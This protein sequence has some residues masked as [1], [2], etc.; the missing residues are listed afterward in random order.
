M[1]LGKLQTVK[2]TKQNTGKSVSKQSAKQT[3]FVKKPRNIS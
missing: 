2:T 3:M 1:N